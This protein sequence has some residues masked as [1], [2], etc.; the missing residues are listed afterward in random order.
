[1]AGGL[2]NAP[3]W[4]DALLVLL[5]AA[6]VFD[7]A[8]QIV[9]TDRRSIKHIGLAMLLVGW[10]SMLARL[11]IEWCREGEATISVLGAASMILIA[12]GTLLLHLSRNLPRRRDA[13]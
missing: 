13:A 7:A 8:W 6:C 10:S 5:C 9:N 3:V 12:S 2:V 11:L 1:M 4:M